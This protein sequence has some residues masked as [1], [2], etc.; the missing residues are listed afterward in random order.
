M[1]PHVELVHAADLEST[2]LPASGWLAGPRVK[3]L[4]ADPDTGALST[5]VTLPPSYRRLQGFIESDCEWL[6][7]SGALRI[8]DSIRGFGWYEFLPAGTTQEVWRAETECELLL[9]SRSGA[10][11]FVPGAGEDPNRDGAVRLDTELVDW[12]VSPIPGPPA[13]HALKIL[14]H[15]RETGEM[16]AL[17]GSVPRRSYTKLQFHD[18]SE[19]MFVISGDVWLRNSGRMVAGSYFWRPP[20]VTHGPFYTETGR[21]SYVYVDGPLINHYVDDPRS[22]PAENRESVRA[23]GPPHDYLVEP[24][25][26]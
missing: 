2:E 14:R 13:G 21:F 3:V 16:A 1:R 6:V 26:S 25:S 24:T 15:D 18:C 9:L 20:F 23:A 22:T 11:D 12:Q 4:S 5:L 17:G 10:P 8:G 7:L 19:E